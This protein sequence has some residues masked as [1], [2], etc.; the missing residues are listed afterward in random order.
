M[1]N[2]IQQDLSG[3]PK[4]SVHQV[5]PAMDEIR[6]IGGP[7]PYTTL[8]KAPEQAEQPGQIQGGEFYEKQYIDRLIAMPSPGCDGP[9][10]NGELA[11]DPEISSFYI[12]PVS[13]TNHSLADAF[14]QEKKSI[15][16]NREPL[17]MRLPFLQHPVTKPGNEPA[18]E[19]DSTEEV[20]DTPIR[21]FA[22][23]ADEDFHSF[24]DEAS[25]MD[26]EE[27]DNEPDSPY[28]K[29]DTQPDA[30]PE[31]QAPPVAAPEP[32]PATE[33]NDPDLLELLASTSLAEALL[34][35]PFFEKCFRVL[36][37][38]GWT[39][40]YAT[41][42]ALYY[43]KGAAKVTFTE[44]ALLKHCW[45]QQQQARVE[46]AQGA[47][48]EGVW[49]EGQGLLE[50]GARARKRKAVVAFDPTPATTSSGVKRKPRSHEEDE[51]EE[52]AGTGFD[53]GNLDEEV[54]AML[55][56]EAA[57]ATAAAQAAAINAAA[58]AVQGTE[59]A[60]A[61]LPAPVAAAPQVETEPVITFATKADRI[62]EK[63]R[64]Y[65]RDLLA[66]ES[67]SVPSP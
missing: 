62:L 3:K 50:T 66:L 67:R 10:F 8:T 63:G 65:I 29:P 16:P 54:A 12:S 18:R 31:T 36:Q 6:L 53:S 44:E 52:S 25:P 26:M 49:M 14:S 32:V 40:K 55:A 21:P 15:E 47:E 20:L 17:T 33:Y 22:G 1:M 9:Q 35:K 56:A 39:Y 43:K 60:E 11:A 57:A 58:A 61:P 48:G 64:G 5:T 30:Q 27:P 34:D 38:Y 51:E 46:G 19:P 24:N 41:L 45:A 42:G 28:W 13:T 4:P 7:T 37:R 23:I 59:G 2:T